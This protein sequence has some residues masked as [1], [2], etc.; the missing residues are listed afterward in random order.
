MFE[1]LTEEA[2]E[3]VGVAND[4]PVSVRAIVWIMAG[5][6]RHHLNILTDRYLQK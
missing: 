3:R 4:N 1:Q 2:W 5:H 6:V